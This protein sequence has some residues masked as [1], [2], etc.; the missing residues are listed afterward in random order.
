MLKRFPH[1]LRELH[2]ILVE[3]SDLST[4][5]TLQDALAHYITIYPS[6]Q[7]KYNT[8][9]LVIPGGGFSRMDLILLADLYNVLGQHERAIETIQRGTRWLQGR[10]DQKYW[11]LCKDDRGYNR[12]DWPARSSFREGGFAPA[13]HF[14]LDPNSRHR[15]AVARIKMSDIEEGMF[16]CLKFLITPFCL[17]KLQMLT[18][19]AKCT[20]KRNPFMNYWVEIQLCV[21]IYFPVQHPNLI[22]RGTDE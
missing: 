5:A 13:G 3:L 8:S 2:T 7:A 19:N 1:V 12:E 18:L 4:R 20:Q 9:G 17:L 6:G 14:E 16:V 22:K 11:D 10:E 15:L 21:K